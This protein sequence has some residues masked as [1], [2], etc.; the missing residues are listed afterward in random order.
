M[1]A[2]VPALFMVTVGADHANELSPAATYPRTEEKK[3]SASWPSPRWTIAASGSAVTV[4]MV[5]VAVKEPESASSTLSSIV[6][7]NLCDIALAQRQNPGSDP[8]S[9]RK[10]FGRL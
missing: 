5:A 1:T 10:I 6:L 9:L 7:A 2:A 8:G 3:V 4:V